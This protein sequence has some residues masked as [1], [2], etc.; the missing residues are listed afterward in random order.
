MAASAILDVWMLH[1]DMWHHT[2][3]L[4]KQLIKTLS[5]HNA[6]ICILDEYLNDFILEAHWRINL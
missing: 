1:R 2:G 3:D 5:Q 6:Y 4:L